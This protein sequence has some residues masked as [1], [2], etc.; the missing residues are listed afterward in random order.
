MMEQ[1]IILNYMPRRAKMRMMRNRR[2]LMVMTVMMILNYM[3]RRAR[4]RMKKNR[5]RRRLMV[6]M[7]R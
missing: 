2:R 3:P 7:T 1:K 5:M 6:M 4:M